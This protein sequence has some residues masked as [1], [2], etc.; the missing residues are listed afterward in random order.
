MTKRKYLKK[1]KKALGKISPAE[2]EDLVAYYAELIDESYDHGK[3]EREIFS[4]LDPPEVA[5]AN[6]LRECPTI[7]EEGKR[8]GHVRNA[9]SNFG[10]IVM[11]FFAAILSIV[12]V[13][14]IVSFASCGVAFAVAGVY[15]LA[16][17]FG[18]LFS[19][20]AAVFF[21][22]WGMAFVLFALAMLS[23]AAAVLLYK[24]FAGMWRFVVGR[25]K[26]KKP[27]RK[28]MRR[29]LIASA[30]ML[31][32]GQ[33]MFTAA[34]GALGFN[35][36]NLAVTEGLATHEEQLSVED[37][38]ALEADNSAVTIKRSEDETCKLVYRD[39][40]ETPKRFVF[41]DGKA[42]LND[43]EGTLSVMG[44]SFELQWRRGLLIGGAATDLQRAELYLP[45]SFSG[46]LTV[47]VDNGEVSVTDMVC[48][49]LVI[50]VKN[51]AVTLDSVTTDTVDVKTNN[52]AVILQS[53]TAETVNAKTSNGAI[54][55]KNVTAE[56][57]TAE[58]KTG[59]IDL[60][61]VACTRVTATTSTGA[62][63]LE[64]LRADHIYLHTSTGSVKGT[65]SGS[66]AEYSVTASVS[67]G[68][69][70]LQN[71][72]GGS[73]QL[74]VRVSTGSVNIKFVG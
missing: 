40:P 13:S 54:Y 16:I 10:K 65:I 12:L 25:P 26:P 49:D 59:A 62:I 2:A 64:D 60:K 39:F 17:S 21:A 36:K 29:A 66:E 45:A 9:A 20:H 74:D 28:S 23:E 11:G 33:L 58:I 51:G 3:T 6:Y 67:T 4:K 57:V 68:S 55:C 41:L 27:M 30:M 38:L 63:L 32:G 8:E 52:G 22:Q 14:L 71:R 72:Q 56:T 69:C 31:L 7:G 5:A 35:Y 50:S 37:A 48:T 44:A 34:F 19:G 15:V 46:A 1:L 61:N 18:L 24:L 42:M 47:E 43:G 70:N 73:K 53:I